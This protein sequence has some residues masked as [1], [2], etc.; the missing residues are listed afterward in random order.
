[1]DDYKPRTK[2]YSNRHYREEEV[3]L[4]VEAEENG[5]KRQDVQMENSTEFA[6]LD[7]CCCSN[8]VGIQ[9]MENYVGNLT[10]EDKLRVRGPEASEKILNLWGR[11]T[12]KINGEWGSTPFQSTYR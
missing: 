11:M 7:M 3:V 4:W 12:T 8:V 2:A 9:W 5:I 10:D 6:I 1:M